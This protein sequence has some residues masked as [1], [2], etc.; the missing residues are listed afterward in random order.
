M[1]MT[2]LSRVTVT[3]SLVIAFASVARAQE[4]SVG[5]VV[6]V[7]LDVGVL[8][9]TSE[10]LA[11]RADVG[12]SFNTFES[13]SQVGLSI[14]GVR[15]TITTTTSSRV[16]TIGLSALFTIRHADNLRLYLAPRGAL[17]LTHQSVETEVE[18]SSPPSSITSLGGEGEDSAQGYELNAMFGGQYRL[19]DRFAV[20]GETGVA[21]RRSE[22]PVV[23]TTLSIGG[24]S[25]GDF[26]RESRTTSIGLRGTVG[27]VLF[28]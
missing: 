15:P 2:F 13:S 9:Q 8:W 27:L 5:L 12:F 16:T 6:G 1:R 18:P 21:Y 14:G 23:I 10:R 7:P 4:K 24:T 26:G 20:F 17:Q 22:L 25:T 19:H 3:A 11:L 28:F